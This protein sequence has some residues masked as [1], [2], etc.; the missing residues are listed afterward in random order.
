MDNKQWGKSTGG[1]G[2]EEGTIGCVDLI[3]KEERRGEC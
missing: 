3:G 1:R 2:L